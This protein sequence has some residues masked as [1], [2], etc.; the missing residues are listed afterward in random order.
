MWA[1]I[2]FTKLGFGDKA[3]EYYRMINPVE[4]SRTKETALKYGD[5]QVH[6]WRRSYDVKPPELSDDDQR[7]LDNADSYAYKLVKLFSIVS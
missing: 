1:I 2:A 7:Y 4:H 5:E 6:I 3:L